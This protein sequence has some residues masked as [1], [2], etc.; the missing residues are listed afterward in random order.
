MARRVFFSF[1]FERDNWR[2]GQVR[3]SGA[4]KDIDDAGYWDHAKWEEI[5][6]KGD[7]VISKWIDDALK[8]SSV[9]VV[10]I[11]KE[12]SGRKWVKY[13][14][15]KSHSKGNGMLGVYIHKVNDKEKK[16]DVKGKNPFEQ[17]YVTRD[18]KKIRLS[19][20]YPTY[21]YVDQGGYTNLGKWIEK[22]AE[23]AGK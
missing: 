8:G 22:A 5:K 15:K 23:K 7:A 18:G 19:E 10:L 2:A 4:F 12:T 9:T 16:T 13:E 20:L 6:K 21:D 11:G 3:N 14:I 1:H 17:F